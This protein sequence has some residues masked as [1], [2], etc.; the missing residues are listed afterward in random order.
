M[1]A[2]KKETEMMEERAKFHNKA[3]AAVREVVIKEIKHDST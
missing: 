1:T 3:S 2:I